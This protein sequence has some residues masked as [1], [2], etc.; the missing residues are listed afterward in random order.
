V[1]FACDSLPFSK[2][3]VRERAYLAWQ[4]RSGL[5]AESA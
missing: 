4:T 5:Y 1:D 2:G 3:A